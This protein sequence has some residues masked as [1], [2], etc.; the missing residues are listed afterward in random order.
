[1]T[2]EMKLYAFQPKGHGQLSFFVMSDSESHA[3]ESVDK[4]IETLFNDKDITGYE[5]LGWDTEEYDMFILG[6]DQVAWNY[7]E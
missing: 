6:A 1:M 4:Q 5:V 7:N 3:M 2:T